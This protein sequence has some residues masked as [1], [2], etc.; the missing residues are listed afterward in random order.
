MEL[1]LTQPQIREMVSAFSKVIPRNGTLPVLHYLQI[2]PRAE[3]IEFT[4]TDLEETLTFTLPQAAGD[5]APFLLPCAEL[6]TLA[7]SLGKADSAILQPGKGT[8]AVTA[9]VE[10]RP[11]ARSVPTLSAEEFPAAQ[12]IPL[13]AYPVGVFLEAYRRAAI[14]TATDETRYVINGVFHHQEA[15]ALVGTDGKRLGLFNIPALPLADFI[16]PPSGLLKSS[17]LSAA[18][19][20]IGLVQQDEVQWVAIQA[21]P[22][23]YQTKCV[24]GLYPNYRQVI[25]AAEAEYTAT[26]QI[27]P[28]DMGLVRT[29]VKQF[30]SPVQTTI[31]VCVSGP[32]VELADAPATGN[33]ARAHV[34]LPKSTSQAAGTV[35]GAV[36]GQFLLDGLEAGFNVLRITDGYSP[37]LCTGSTPGL[38]VV[39]PMRMGAPGQETAQDEPNTKGDTQVNTPQTPGTPEGPA[40]EPQGSGLQIVG[41]PIDELMA[42][43][44]VAQE[45]V[46]QAHAALHGIKGKLRAVEKHF[47]ARQKEFDSTRK[48]IE[49]LKDAAGF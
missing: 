39:M 19:G 40:G 10:G 47:R 45:S 15:Q 16:L 36:N 33:E 13:Q 5:F 17:V 26:I 6:K 48:V 21:G 22:W 31:Y 28:D 14:F 32:A 43:V 9:V 23:T 35:T 34:L 2:R 44:A 42:A 29:A 11:I 30:C 49:T 25:P 7:S 38:H 37:W 24:E 1:T 46:R 12:P 3:G 8:V 41:D 20:A 18:A 4:A 27:H